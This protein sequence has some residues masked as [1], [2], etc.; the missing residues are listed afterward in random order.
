MTS[1]GTWHIADADIYINDGVDWSGVASGGE[2]LESAII[3]EFGH[4]WGGLHCCEHDGADGAPRCD[5]APQCADAILL[6]TLDSRVRRTPT[7]DDRGALCFLYPAQ[8][9]A[10]SSCPDCATDAECGDGRQCF[11][12]TCIDVPEPT[13]G[14]SS[15]SQCP[16]P[17]RCEAGRCVSGIAGDPCAAATDCGSGLCREGVCTT[18]CGEGCP[19]GFVCTAD[20]CAPSLGVL[21]DPCAMPRECA[22][23]VCVEGT[24][25]PAICSRVCTAAEPCPGGW[26]CTQVDRRDVCV[27]S[28]SP[29]CAIARGERPPVY[30]LAVVA[31][32][33]V[34]RRRR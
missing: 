18:D 2:D 31:A 34:W 20:E 4:A 16:M 32:F 15:D 33:L 8:E 29:G 17:Y 13:P 5:A 11:A 21:G 30:W 24:R 6:P 22:G 19:S 27:L 28:P 23:G 7:E 10:D 1:E 9:C 12:G 26:T 3:H 25:S 14:C